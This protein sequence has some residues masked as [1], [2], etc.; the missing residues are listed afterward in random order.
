MWV[1]EHL[2]YRHPDG[3]VVLLCVP[4]A[5]TNEKL[6]VAFCVCP[7]LWDRDLVKTGTYPAKIKGEAKASPS[8]FIF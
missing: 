3:R 4:R 2:V 6:Y 5:L 7:I 8:I 1:V